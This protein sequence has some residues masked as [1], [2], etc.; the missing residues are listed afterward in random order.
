MPRRFGSVILLLG[1]AAVM[2]GAD[3]RPSSE[4]RATAARE[5]EEAL[6]LEPNLEKGLQIYRTCARCHQPEGWGLPDGSYPQLA[7]QHR[8]VIVKQLADIRAGVRDNPE[9]HPYAS[10]EK[11]GG[12]QGVADVAGYI[13]TL[14]ISIDTGKGSGE[15]LELGAKLYRAKCARCHGERGEGDGERYIPRIQSQHYAYLVRQLQAIRDGRRGNADA[16][17]ATHTQEISDEEARAVADYV[18]RLEPPA[19]FQAPA[20]WRNPDFPRRPR[21][22]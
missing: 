20:G 9:M 13:D 16:E 3:E 19:E 17:M 2:L 21:G 1:L 14:E 6:V 10:P 18:S 12:A 7:G 4:S 5:L 8:T 15:R 22:S 11:L